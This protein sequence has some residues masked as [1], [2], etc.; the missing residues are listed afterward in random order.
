LIDRRPG[1][2]SSAGKAVATAEVRRRREEERGSIVEVDGGGWK[3][4][5]AEAEGEGGRTSSK[6]SWQIPDGLVKKRVST[7]SCWRDGASEQGSK[8][9]EGPGQG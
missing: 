9:K 3:G 4:R 6:S 7:R 5:E 2:S 8:R 1:R